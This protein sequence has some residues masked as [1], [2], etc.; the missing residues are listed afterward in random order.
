MILDRSVVYLTDVFRGQTE[1]E[2]IYSLQDAKH[3]VDYFV[4]IR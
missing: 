2:I 4:H 1:Y 3:Q